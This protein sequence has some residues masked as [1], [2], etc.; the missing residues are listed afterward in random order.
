MNAIA[1]VITERVGVGMRYTVISCSNAGRAIFFLIFLVL[2]SAI[3]VVYESYTYK[4]NFSYYQKLN[5]EKQFLAN[6]YDNL[7][8]EKSVLQSQ[9]RLINVAK[10]KLQMHAYDKDDEL[11]I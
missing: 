7:T 3:C 1:K 10:N 8:V 4:Q 6:L 2:F 9:I 11:I 5:N